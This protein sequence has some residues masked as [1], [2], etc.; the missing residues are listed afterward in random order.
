MYVG[1]H[2]AY[3]TATDRD[4]EHAVGRPTKR[5]RKEELSLS[6]NKHPQSDFLF[7]SK[8]PSGMLVQSAARLG[9]KGFP[10]PRTTQ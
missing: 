9:I 8:Q 6:G 2:E 1:G 5:T 4:F 10:H 3:Q 7:T